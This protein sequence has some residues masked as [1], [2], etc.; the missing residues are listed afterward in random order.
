M[1]S[2][3]VRCIW[4]RHDLETMRKRLKA[5]EAKVAQEG[6]VLT[7]ALR[8]VV[9]RAIC[10]IAYSTSAETRF[11][12]IGFCREMSCNA[13]SPPV[14]IEFFEPIEA[15]AAIAHQLTGLRNIAELLRQFQHAHLRLDDLLFCRH[16]PPSL[17]EVRALPDCQINF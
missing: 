9:A 2:L 3:R 10:T 1:N 6:V 16:R 13:A 7:E 5:L 15:V 17:I 11:L 8:G 4:L 12:R 14:S